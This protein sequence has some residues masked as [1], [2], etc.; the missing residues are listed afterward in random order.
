MPQSER[1]NNLKKILKWLNSQKEGATTSAL[2]FHIKWGITE[3]GATDTTIKNYL[4][5]LKSA[6][7]IAYKHPRWHITDLGKKWL[8]QHNF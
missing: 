6:G 3:G 4:E 1:S 5:D 8:Q 2:R 7:F